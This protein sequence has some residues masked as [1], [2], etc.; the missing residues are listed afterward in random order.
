MRAAVIKYTTN[1]LI[2]CIPSYT[3]RH[4]WYQHVLSWYLGPNAAVLM[5]QYVHGKNLRTNGK[6]VSIGAGT[7]IAHG[8]LLCAAGVLLIG[9]NVY[10]SPGVL[11]LTECR[12]I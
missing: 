4:A 7:V 10:I 9:E 2:S 11:L 1:D 3:I 5:G 12:D 6:R 8:R